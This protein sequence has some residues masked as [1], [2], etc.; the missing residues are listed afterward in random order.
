MMLANNSLSHHPPA[1]WSC[2]SAD[3]ASAAGNSNLALG[4]DATDAIDMYIQD[5]GSS[6]LDAGHRRWILYSRAGV[7]GAGS[8][9]ASQA[10]WILGGTR[11]PDTLPEFIAWPPKGYVPAPLVYNRWSFAIPSADFSTATVQMTDG[12]GASVSCNI[13]SNHVTLYGDNT[14]VWEPAGIRTNTATDEVYHVTV[15]SVL[16][17]GIAKNFSYD[18]T[19][20]QADGR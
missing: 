9:S 1:S 3:G 15:G 19:I 20:I 2:Y 4:A 6:N 17:S 13:I 8:T 16:V 11:T 18:V 7:M 5:P 10:L 12:S 14:I